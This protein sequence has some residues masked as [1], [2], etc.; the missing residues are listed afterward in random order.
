MVM[1]S[2][3]Y[4]YTIFKAL[5]AYNDECTENIKLCIFI[6]FFFFESIVSKAGVAKP[7]IEIDRSISDDCKVDRY[8]FYLH[9]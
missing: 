1:A 9:R 7:S 8:E 4:V 2:I 3:L 6:F 5:R